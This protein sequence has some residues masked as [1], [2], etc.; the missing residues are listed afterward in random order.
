[1]P[2]DLNA[3]HIEIAALRRQRDQRAREH[4]RGTRDS[5]A[6]ALAAFDREIALRQRTIADALAPTNPPCPHCGLTVAEGV[7]H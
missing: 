3:L 4:W 6:R 5:R 2:L 1:M 7:L